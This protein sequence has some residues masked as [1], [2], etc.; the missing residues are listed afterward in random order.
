MKFLH[1][2]NNATFDPMTHPHPH[3]NKIYEV[4]S[5]LWKISS[6]LCSWKKLAVDESLIPYKVRLG[7]KQHI[8]MKRARFG[9]NLF[10]KCESL[11]GY[12]RYMLIYSGKDTPFHSNYEKYGI[13]TCSLM[14]SS[15]ALQGKIYCFRSN[16]NILRKRLSV[17]ISGD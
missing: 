15:Q 5:N 7:Y 17:E 11:S 16:Y 9:V 1:L 2:K 14:T 10:K 13:G 4:S 12:I 3:I 8:S 6:H